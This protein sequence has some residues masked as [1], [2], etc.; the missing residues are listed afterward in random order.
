MYYV[1]ILKSLKTGQYYKGLTNNISRRLKEHLNGSSKTTKK[2]LPLQLMFVQICE[3]RIEARKLEKY[4]KTGY[5]REVINEIMGFD[6][7]AGRQVP[8]FGTKYEPS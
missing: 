1:Y 8:S 3:N 4:F 2:Y 7:P 5:G 6:L